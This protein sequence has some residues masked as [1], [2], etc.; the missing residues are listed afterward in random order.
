MLNSIFH[1]AWRE[2]P[3]LLARSGKPLKTVMVDEVA[4]TA[5]GSMFFKKSPVRENTA[6]SIFSLI[7]ASKT[8]KAPLTPVFPRKTINDRIPCPKVPLKPRGA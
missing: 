7:V 6:S 4:L 1:W 3:R 5:F 8:I 2:Y